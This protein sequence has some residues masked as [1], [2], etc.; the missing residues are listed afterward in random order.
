MC[1]QG[2]FMNPT[3]LSTVIYG[4]FG[5]SCFWFSHLTLFT[6][7]IRPWSAHYDS[8]IMRRH[9]VLARGIALRE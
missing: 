7:E 6:Q 8:L 9:A 3:S 2:R 1:D 4:G 5:I